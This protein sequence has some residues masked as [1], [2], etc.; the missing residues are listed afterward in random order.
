M[1]F[2]HIIFMCLFIYQVFILRVH[3]QLDP[4]SPENEV[5]WI[6]LLN[7]QL[8]MVHKTGNVYQ[9]VKKMKTKKMF[10]G[11]GVYVVCA[12]TRFLQFCG[13]CF[14][15]LKHNGIFHSPAKEYAFSCFFSVGVWIKYGGKIL[16]NIYIH[17]SPTI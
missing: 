17:C 15:I 11:H 3:L 7:I 1:Y 5:L 14:F 10:I 4:F 6:E 9:G 13:S 8:V 2:I 16:K 12:C